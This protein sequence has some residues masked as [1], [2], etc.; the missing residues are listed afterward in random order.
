[1]MHEEALN[2]CRQA[3]P[4]YAAEIERLFEISPLFASLM[5]TADADECRRIFKDSSDAVLPDAGSDWFPAGECADEES[6]KAVLRRV[7]QRALRHIIW[8]EMGLGGDILVSAASISQLAANLIQAALDM[9]PRLLA[10]RFGYLSSGSFTVIGL[11]KLGGNELNLGSDVDLLFIW[12]AEGDQTDGRKRVEPAVYYQHMSRLMMRLLAEMTADGRVWPVDMRLRPGGDAAPICLSIEATLQHYQGYGQTWERAMLIKSR[13]VAGDVELGQAFIDGIHPFVYRRYLDYTTV[14][15]LAEMK[16]RIDAQAGEMKIG[17]GFDVKRGQGG[18]REIEF[19]IQSLQLLHGGRQSALRCQPSMAAL[20]AL[21]E[22]GLVEAE[23]AK[24]LEDAYKFWRQV[25][26]AVQAQKG[27]QTQVLPEDYVAFLAAALGRDDVEDLMQQH[28]AVV[29]DNFQAQ[30]ATL[31]HEEE[32]SHSWLDQTEADWQQ[33]LDGVDGESVRRM[34]HA[35][36]DIL[37][38]SERGLL[39]ERSHRQIVNLVDAAMRYWEGDANRVL[40]LESLAGLLRRIAGRATWIDLMDHHEGVRKWLFD[41]LSASRYIAEHI[42][43]DPSWLEWPLEGERGKSRMEQLHQEFSALGS[44]PLD[45]EQ[46]LAEMSRLINQSRLTASMTVT[47]DEEDP[48]VIGSWLARTADLTTRAVLSLSLRQL[49]LPEDFPFV[50]LAMGKHGSLEM[51][52]VSDLDM[53]FLL[54]HESPDSAGPKG[55]SQR[56]WSQRLGRR[57]IQHLTT[58][59][60]YGAGYEFDARLRPSGQSG[61]LTTTIEAFLEYQLLEAQTWEHQALCRARPVTGPKAAQARV[62]Q[63]ID[64]VIA[65]PRDAGLLAHNVLEMRAKML[66]HLG[67][68]SAAVINLKHNAGGLVDLEFLAQ[69]A[70][71]RFAGSQL[72]TAQTLRALPKAAPD[73]WQKL[74]PELAQT[75]VDYR[76]MENALRVQLWQSIGKLSADESAVE[77]E[78]MRRH[79]AIKSPAELEER[80]R[81]VREQFLL[82]LNEVEES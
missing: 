65:Q 20:A 81:W 69:Y 28:A 8:W 11:G 64:D 16:R 9:T 62:A 72:G 52:M 5:R 24:G 60:P 1:M 35:L 36:Q 40:A 23:Q 58:P 31:A 76:Q 14:Q 17:A 37:D 18:I 10:P 73:I 79:A 30:F 51:G 33:R 75:Y 78:T 25:E 2:R 32:A 53:V 57:M 39:P 70:R 22:A 29:Q 15:A 63:V 45:D 4:E 41:A 61:V 48:L 34:C 42:V 54:V 66:D 55:K 80:M 12:Q 82:L 6:C 44:E 59:A 21:V 77:W 7:K 3:A 27:E 46:Y 47:A 26:H 68:K 49:G 71:L 56:E 38:I 50:C 67:S 13:P 74:G 19:F 43:A